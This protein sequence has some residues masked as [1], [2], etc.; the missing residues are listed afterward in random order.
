LSSF[1]LYYPIVQIKGYFLAI[2]A[3]KGVITDIC[4]ESSEVPFFLLCG[5][6]RHLTPAAMGQQAGCRR[7]AFLTPAHFPANGPKTWLEIGPADV[8]W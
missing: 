8:L 7:N 1:T 4:P 5:M 3:G 2:E 6:R